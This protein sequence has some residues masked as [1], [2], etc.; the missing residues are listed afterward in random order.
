MMGK[1]GFGIIGTIQAICCNVFFVG[2]GW[3][4]VCFFKVFDVPVNRELT[5]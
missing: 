5:H 4:V 3:G 2:V 1:N